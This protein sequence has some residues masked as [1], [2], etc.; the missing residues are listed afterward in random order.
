MSASRQGRRDPRG[1]SGQR[2]HGTADGGL[3]HAETFCD[4]GLASGTA[5]QLQHNRQRPV[6]TEDSCGYHT[7]PERV[8]DTGAEV[9]GQAR[10]ILM[11]KGLF[12]PTALN[13]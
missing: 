6:A 1:L 3:A 4:V 13:K 11:A 7:A 9:N 5:P 10:A 2:G 12:F 8:R